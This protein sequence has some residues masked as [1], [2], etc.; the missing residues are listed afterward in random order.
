MSLSLH[1]HRHPQQLAQDCI[2]TP[3]EGLQ[4]QK[5]HSH[6]GQ[7]VAVHSKDI[8]LFHTSTAC[9]GRSDHRITVSSDLEKTFKHH[10]VQFPFKEQ[11][12]FQLSQVSHSLVQ[13]DLKCLQGR[14]IHHLPVQPV[15]VLPSLQPSSYFFP[16][17]SNLNLPFQF[18]TSPL[19]LSQK[20]LLKSPSPSISQ[21]S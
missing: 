10:L 21:T 9:L 18:K 3:F 11:R 6:S 2:Q 15:P 19:V 13:P 12:H 5:W 20:T 4:G 7:Q 1:K 16:L 8:F 14:G 17:I